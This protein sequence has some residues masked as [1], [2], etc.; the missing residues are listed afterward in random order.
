MRSLLS[1]V[2]SGAP[3][4]HFRHMSTEVKTEQAS[5]FLWGQVS[6]KKHS[7]MH[8]FYV[9]I[10]IYHLLWYHLLCNW[11]TSCLTFAKPGVWQPQARIVLSLPKI[12]SW[13]WE[14][15]AWDGC[16]S[17]GLAI[18]R[19]SCAHLQ[20]PNSSSATR[21]Y[22]SEITCNGM[23][24]WRQRPS[25]CRARCIPWFDHH[26]QSSICTQCSWL[27]LKTMTFLEG[28]ASYCQCNPYLLWTNSQT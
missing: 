27:L 19:R 18:H 20:F 16:P 7:Y 26:F 4:S 17:P 28:C 12:R 10:Y 3:H 15:S 14:P 23:T 6:P 5:R 13:L 1:R 8:I 11:C 21:A 9:Y 22:F 24:L 25:C 2:S